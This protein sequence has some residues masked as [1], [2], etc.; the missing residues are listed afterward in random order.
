MQNRQWRLKRLSPARVEV[1]DFEERS[2]P[3]PSLRLGEVFIRNHW[4]SC[5]P[6]IRE[7]FNNSATTSAPPINPGDVVRCPSIG[8]VELSR[9]PTYREGDFVWGLFGWQEYAVERAGAR[10]GDDGLPAREWRGNPKLKPLT[11]GLD[12]KLALGAIGTNGL[13][14][15]FGLLEVARVMPG[16][17]VAITGA[18]GATGSLAGQIAKLLGCQVVGLTGHA[19]KCTMLVNQLGFD[20]A[21]SYRCEDLDQRLKGLCPD[22]F[23]VVFDTAQG[24]ALSACL[25]HLARGA[26]VALCGGMSA[27]STGQPQALHGLKN[28]ARRCATLR[29]FSVYEFPDRA[30]EALSQLS[31]WIQGGQLCVLEDVVH[32][33]ES[34][35]AAFVGVLEGDNVGKRLVHLSSPR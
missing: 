16:D 15:Y 32:G 3:T 27:I 29:G 18:A 11:P 23:D 25:R 9:S 2:V 17:R 20:A 8:Q 21:L 10:W 24:T 19:R 5:S 7:W 13:A 26:R 1:G 22:G 14:A 6:Q 34:I 31:A 35:P 4:L 30:P 12:P 28:A 33:F